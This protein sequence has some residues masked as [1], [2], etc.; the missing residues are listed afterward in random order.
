MG[1]RGPQGPG[2]IGSQQGMNALPKSARTVS[3]PSALTR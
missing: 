3:L 2:H 1:P